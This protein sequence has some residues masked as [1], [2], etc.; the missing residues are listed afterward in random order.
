MTVV[1]SEGDLEEDVP[2]FLFVHWHLGSLGSADQTAKITRSAV[3]A[4]S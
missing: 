3:L 2:D 4:V 1:E